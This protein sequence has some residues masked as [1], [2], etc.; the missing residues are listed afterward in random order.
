MSALPKKKYTAEEY[1]ALE[2]VAE[3]KSEF[4][5]GEI[6]PMRGFPFRHN[7]IKTNLVC[8]IGNRLRDGEFQSLSSTM[9]I[10]VEATGLQTY[11][12]VLILGR[13]PKFAD[14]TRECLLNP[15]SSSRFAR[16]LRRI[17]KH[18]TAGSR[19]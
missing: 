5:R 14:D 15:R 7:V 1:V 19:A 18:T 4:Y 6:F 3:Y 10:G 11:P 2:C 17:G 8:E 13:D 9:R 12:D 16:G